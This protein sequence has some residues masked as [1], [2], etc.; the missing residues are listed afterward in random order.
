M[1]WAGLSSL[2]SLSSRGCICY[3]PVSGLARPGL[4]SPWRCGA[5]E[6][7]PPPASTAQPRLAVIHCTAL[8]PSL[9]SRPPIS[10]AAGPGHHWARC[11]P[12][13]LSGFVPTEERTPSVDCRAASTGP[14]PG[15]GGLLS[16]RPRSALPSSGSGELLISDMGPAAAAAG[17]GWLLVLEKV[18]S[19]GS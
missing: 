3:W 2:C 9:A 19:E 16:S 1:C 6:A 15:M 17:G 18:P 14:G 7:T 13:L 11:W 12:L 5:A 10:V 4:A 8:P